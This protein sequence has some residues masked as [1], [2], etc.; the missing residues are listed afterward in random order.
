MYYM[1][2]LSEKLDSM[3]RVLILILFGIFVSYLAL[4]SLFSTQY[5]FVGEAASVSDSPVKALLLYVLLVGAVCLWKKFRLSRYLEPYQKLI[6]AAGV[7]ALLIFLV[8]FIL[9]TQ[10]EPHGD[11]LAI[12]SAADQI[13]NYNF[14]QF[15][16]GNY[17]DYWPFQSR[18]V[19]FLWFFFRIFGPSNYYAFHFLNA[20]S[21]VISLHLVSRIFSLTM[22]SEE[23]SKVKENLIFFTCMMFLPFLMYVTFIYGNLPG[24]AFILGAV[25]WEVRFMKEHKGYQLALMAL[26]CAVGVWLKNTYLIFV[27]AIVVFLLVDFWQRRKASAIVGAVCVAAAISLINMGSDLIL[28]HRMG[29]ELSEGSPMI[30]WVTMAFG[31]DENGNPVKFD[32][33]NVDVYTENGRDTA[34]AQEAAIKELGRRLQNLT[35][36]SE[37]FIR[38]MGRKLA[39]EW[40]EPTF[41]SVVANNRQYP[42]TEKPESMERLLQQDNRSILVKYANLFHAMV[43]LGCVTWVFLKG[44]KASPQELFFALIFVGG[45][46]FQLFWETAAQYTLPFFL[47]LIPYAVTGYL[48]AGERVLAGVEGHRVD[49]AMLAGYGVAAV[50][51]LLTGVSGN[52]VIHDLFKVDHDTAA[53]TE[54]LNEIISQELADAGAVKDGHYIVT[55]VTMPDHG[56]AVLGEL[57]KDEAV[58]RATPVRLVPL[59]ENHSGI[60]E[61]HHEYNYDLLRLQS[62]QLLL[63]LSGEPDDPETIVGQDFDNACFRIIEAEGKGYA[64]TYG[65]DYALTCDGEML[66]IRPYDGN[67]NQ[68]WTLQRR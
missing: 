62:T 26:L 29:F 8:W 4:L 55:P 31:E 10:L 40:N 11:Q 56:I 14:S 45:F 58:N 7:I 28:E 13:Q 38:F 23:Q 60:L 41:E 61:I 2:S 47:L 65:N 19:V 34:R 46:L 67:D 17:F 22:H 15:V 39:I 37:H 5:A 16:Q 68:I 35:D 52:Q 51:I 30:A 32:S 50:V 27:V 1:T 3:F 44:K 54:H 36:T 43:L 33:Y 49:R 12:C 48:A 64:I 6:K 20:V 66:T 24:L 9:S 57:S 25:Y 21:I 53:Y 18:I 42:Q 59:D 63:S